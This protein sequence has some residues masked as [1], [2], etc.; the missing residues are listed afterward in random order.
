MYNHQANYV[1]AEQLHKRA[2]AIREKA[3]GARHPDVAASL[4]NLASVYHEQ[5]KYAEAERHSKRAVA[6]YEKTLGANHPDLAYALTALLVSHWAVDSEAATQL[7]ISTFDIIKSD[8]RLGRAEALRRAMLALMND[9][10]DPLN[11]YPAL[12][13][14][15]VVVGEGAAR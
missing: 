6:I 11:A 3:L 5:G 4:N 14:P 10:T 7:I 2:L 9:K 8:P 15:F 13:A 12:W 1:D